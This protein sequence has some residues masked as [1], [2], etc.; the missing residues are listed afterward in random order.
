MAKVRHVIT[1]TVRWA[2]IGI[3]IE[4]AGE[5]SFAGLLSNVDQDLR[6]IFGQA[7]AC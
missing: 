4:F 7:L 3:R 2:V 1:D 6:T 5:G